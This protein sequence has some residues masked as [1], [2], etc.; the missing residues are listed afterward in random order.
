MRGQW[1]AKLT[2]DVK[3]LVVLLECCVG[4]CLMESIEVIEDGLYFGDVGMVVK[5]P[6]D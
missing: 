4:I 1:K 5:Y 3:A 2:E 6:S